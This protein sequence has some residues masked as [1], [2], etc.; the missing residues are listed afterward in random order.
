MLI[1]LGLVGHHLHNPVLPDHPAQT[2]TVAHVTDNAPGTAGSALR[3]IDH[4]AAHDIDVE[5]CVP[6]G[7]VPHMVTTGPGDIAVLPVAVQGDVVRPAP[8]DAPAWLV[9]ALA[10]D[11]LRALLQVFLN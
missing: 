9:P 3:I 6:G 8:S 7:Q 4:G 10:P 1:L 2:L 5:V 11:V